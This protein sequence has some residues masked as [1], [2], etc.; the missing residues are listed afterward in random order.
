MKA[1]E[2]LV[3]RRGFFFSADDEDNAGEQ[4][5]PEGLAIRIHLIRPVADHQLGTY[6]H[7]LS[8]GRLSGSRHAIASRSHRTAADT[9]ARPTAVLRSATL[10]GTRRRSRSPR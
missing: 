3:R 2:P 4:E 9:D 5:G 8:G 10:T 7:G 6:R 1:A